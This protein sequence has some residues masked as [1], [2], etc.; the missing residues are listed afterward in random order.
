ML[1]VLDLN[2]VTL[3]GTCK[4]AAVASLFIEEGS[5]SRGKWDVDH[6]EILK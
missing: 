1:L 3:R 2:E 5:Y 4:Y 6:A